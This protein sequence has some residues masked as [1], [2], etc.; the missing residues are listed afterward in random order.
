MSGLKVQH[1]VCPCGAVVKCLAWTQQ[2]LGSNHSL[3]EVHFA[4]VLS[5]ISF[6]SG[7]LCMSVA[8]TFKREGPKTRFYYKFNPYFFSQTESQYYRD[9]VLPK[10]LYTFQMPNS[11]SLRITYTAKLGDRFNFNGQLNGVIFERTSH[12]RDASFGWY[13]NCYPCLAEFQ[14]DIV[15]AYIGGTGGYLVVIPFGGNGTRQ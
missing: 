4:L 3:S 5:L 9:F 2:V 1:F 14:V 6:D 11:S 8:C 7:L 12:I 15:S 13:M 10:G